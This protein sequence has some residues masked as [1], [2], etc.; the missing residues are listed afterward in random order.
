MAVPLTGTLGAGSYDVAQLASGGAD[1]A[2]VPGVDYTNAA[3]DLATAGGT[4][5]IAKRT[6]GYDPGTGDFGPDQFVADLVGWGSSNV[7]EDTAAD[8]AALTAATSLTRA[9]GAVDTD[10]NADDFA[11]DAPNPNTAPTVPT[12][13]DRGDPGHRPDHADGERPGGHHRRRDR[14]VPPGD[15]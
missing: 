14:G 2:A 8:V 10:M 12:Q 7:A 11:A 3:L 5:F 4:V 6:S 9:P 13:D 1:G 15:R